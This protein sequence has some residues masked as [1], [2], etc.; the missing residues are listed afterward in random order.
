MRNMC[1]EKLETALE[2]TQPEISKRLNKMEM[3]QKRGI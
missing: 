3:I 2:I 1:Q